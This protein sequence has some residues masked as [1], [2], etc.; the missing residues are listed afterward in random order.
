[1]KPAAKNDPAQMTFAVFGAPVVVSLGGGEYNIKPGILLS[2]LTPKQ[3]GQQ[4]GRNRKTVY[5]W[6]EEGIIDQKYVEYSG[7]RCIRI[8]AE[9]VPVLQAYF[10][11]KRGA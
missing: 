9:A 2:M 6:I 4:F 5:N 7:L 11:K 1:M 3:F 8:S 10:R